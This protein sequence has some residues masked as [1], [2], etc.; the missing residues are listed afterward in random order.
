MKKFIAI[1]TATIFLVVSCISAIPVYAADSYDYTDKEFTIK[2]DDDLYFQHHSDGTCDI[3]NGNRDVVKTMTASE[4]EH[5]FIALNITF[6]KYGNVS[7]QDD[8]LQRLI[9]GTSLMIGAAGDVTKTSKVVDDFRKYV[10]HGADAEHTV[11]YQ[12]ATDTMQ[13]ATVSNNGTITF[14][15]DAIKQIYNTLDEYFPRPVKY[16][17]GVKGFYISVSDQD[18][19]TLKQNIYN[20]ISSAYK[21]HNETRNFNASSLSSEI[22]RLFDSIYAQGYD[23]IYL[24]YNGYYKCLEQIYCFKSD[25]FKYYV[26]SSPY[27]YDAD[28]LPCTPEYLR[29][30]FNDMVNHM[31]YD[32]NGNLYYAAV[33]DDGNVC[34]DFLSYSFS[35]I[36]NFSVPANYSY[37][38]IHLS[39][40]EYFNAFKS[41]QMMN[42]YLTGD[43]KGYTTTSFD[44][45]KLPATVSISP[46]DMGNISG[47]Y[48]EML[49]ELEKSNDYDAVFEKYLHELTYRANSIDDTLNNGAVDWRL[50]NII[51]WLEKINSTLNSGFNSM[52]SIKDDLKDIKKGIKD[53]GKDVAS[54]KTISQ[55]DLFLNAL[56]TIDSASNK[57]KISSSRDDLTTSY[58]KLINNK[59]PFSTLRD[60]YYI[61]V[62]F[63]ATPKTPEFI[64]DINIPFLDFK[65]SVTTDLSAFNKLAAMSRNFIIIL[66]IIYLDIKTHKLFFNGK[67][68]K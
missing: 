9:R 27:F 22:S 31:E 33:D 1:I 57:S 65:Y 67:G 21:T 63:S 17:P 24:W 29:F 59:F 62:A 58:N 54:L 60:L 34:W 61:F 23:T 3:L 4:T 28:G 45:G 35:D 52:Y 66:Y 2:Y 18:E 39:S 68:V 46:D 43:V 53:I 55:I 19:K 25:S 26:P 12:Y 30:A 47:L 10:F 41:V 7:I 44:S 37:R 38:F 11:A 50:R 51:E 15:E 49:K 36:E 16:A 48:D 20:L 40:S 5:K 56:N 14:S 64:F 8:L 32:D 6:D 13:N 42:K